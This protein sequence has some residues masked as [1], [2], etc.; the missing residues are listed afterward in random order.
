[1]VP[2]LPLTVT[3]R[4]D[5]SPDESVVGYRLYRGHATRIYQ[6]VETL[7]N[8]TTVEVVLHEPKT[9]FAVT[10]YGAEGFESSPCDELAIDLTILDD[11]AAF[12]H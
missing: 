12:P 6:K 3:L 8:Q 5:P 9:Y 1:V 10:A 2:Q 11:P 4:W 7:G